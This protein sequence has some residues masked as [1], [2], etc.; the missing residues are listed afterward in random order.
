[1]ENSFIATLPIYR[2]DYGNPSDVQ[3]I[4]IIL[5]N[6]YVLI[7]NLKNQAN[8]AIEMLR[9]KLCLNAL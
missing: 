2:I 3:G 8:H 7:M 5:L 6:M 4:M 1:M 9:R